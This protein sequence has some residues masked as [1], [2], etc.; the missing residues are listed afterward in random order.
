MLNFLKGPFV[1]FV[2]L[3]GVAAASAAPLQTVQNEKGTF[4]QDQSGTWH[5]YNRGREVAPPP[6]VAEAPLDQAKGSIY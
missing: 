5:Q 1:A 2:F 3:A 6:A 4:I